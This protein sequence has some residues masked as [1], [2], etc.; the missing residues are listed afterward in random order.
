MIF[1]VLRWTD[2]WG[3]LSIIVFISLLI[4]RSVALPAKSLW[5]SL[6]VVKK[7]DF[8]I[9]WG[10]VV[11]MKHTTHVLGFGITCGIPIQSTHT[12]IHICIM[13]IYIYYI[14]NQYNIYI[15]NIYIRYIYIYVHI[16]IILYKF[17]RA[18]GFSYVPWWRVGLY[19]N[20]GGC[21]SIH[22]VRDLYNLYTTYVWIPNI[23]D[24]LLLVKSTI[25]RWC[26]QRYNLV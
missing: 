20:I 21:S 5:G 17:T 4:T 13:C 10:D 25:T 8:I 18:Y 3:P 11:N 9:Q 19:A 2:T 16:Y 6:I 23:W 7:H 26:P 24:Q 12:H 1:R 22:Q 15:Y 14:I